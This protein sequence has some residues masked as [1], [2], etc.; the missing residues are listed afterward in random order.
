MQ[1]SVRETDQEPH[2]RLGLACNHATGALLVRPGGVS[3]A[4]WQLIHRN[5]AALCFVSD[6]WE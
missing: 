4:V 3:D 6:V 1:G 2:V 5:F